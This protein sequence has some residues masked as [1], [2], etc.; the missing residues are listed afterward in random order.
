MDTLKHDVSIYLP[1]VLGIISTLTWLTAFGMAI[2]NIELKASEINIVSG[3]YALAYCL[4]S[5]A[6]I[7]YILAYEGKLHPGRSFP[8]LFLIGEPIERV[9]I[10]EEGEQIPVSKDPTVQPR[11]HV[12]ETGEELSPVIVKNEDGSEKEIDDP[13]GVSVGAGRYI[14]VS[15]L[16]YTILLA[17]VCLV[18]TRFYKAATMLLVP[19]EG[20]QLM[21]IGVYFTDVIGDI[22]CSRY[23]VC[24]CARGDR[25]ASFTGAAWFIFGWLV[26]LPLA[27][28]PLAMVFTL[29]YF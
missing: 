20:L 7:V 24:G 4:L 11:I 28:L 6:S 25:K 17:W 13:D 8:R 18:Y 16:I 3:S 26:F 2:T 14:L 19:L 29:L 5:A 10:L 21:A 15:M 22:Q 1:L 27:A 12:E 23:Q 9:H